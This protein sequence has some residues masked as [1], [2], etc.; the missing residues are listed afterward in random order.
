MLT[1]EGQEEGAT[2]G[3]KEGATEGNKE[4]ATEDNGDEVQIAVQSNGSRA[5]DKEL[6]TVKIEVSRLRWGHDRAQIY[7]H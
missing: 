6:T 2:E 1:L 4:G 7:R 5:E 3:N